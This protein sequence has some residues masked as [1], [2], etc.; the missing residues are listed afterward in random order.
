LRRAA[1]AMAWTS[2]GLAIQPIRKRA[3]RMLASQGRSRE[4]REERV[5]VIVSEYEIRRKYHWINM[6]RV[7]KDSNTEKGSING[8]CT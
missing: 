2:A 6:W 3:P 7:E 4:E 5:V 1:R 8:D